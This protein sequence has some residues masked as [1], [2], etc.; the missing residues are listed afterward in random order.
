MHLL[1][2]SVLRSSIL[3]IQRRM[4]NEGRQEANDAQ[5]EIDGVGVRK[6]QKSIDSAQTNEELLVFKHTDGC[7]IPLI[8]KTA[9]RGFRLSVRGFRL[10][11]CDVAAP[12]CQY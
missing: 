7:S 2:D 9:V 3:F 6:R 1:S 11:L 8:M 4:A 12:E 10:S 5:M